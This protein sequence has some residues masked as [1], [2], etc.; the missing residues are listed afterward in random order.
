MNSYKRDSSPVP[1]IVGGLSAI[2]LSLFWGPIGLAVFP[3]FYGLQKQA[4]TKNLDCIVDE[5]A[6]SKLAEEWKTERND[7]NLEVSTTTYAGFHLPITRTIYFKKDD[8]EKD[9]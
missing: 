5:D 4:N 7:H 6:V 3:L 8:E 1:A 2:G 9:D